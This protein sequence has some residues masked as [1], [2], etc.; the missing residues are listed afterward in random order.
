MTTK[1]TDIIF[2]IGYGKCASSTLQNAIFPLTKG[3]L[4][5]G[6]NT[7]SKHQ[8]SK[9]FQ[10]LAP[11]GPSIVGSIK[12]AKTW[13]KQVFDLKQKEFPDVDRLIVSS[14]FFLFNNI[15]KNR[16]IIPF[17]K[18]F[19]DTIWN[20]GEIKILIIIRNQAE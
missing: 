9:K 13:A 3:Y 10:A 14:E 18:Q 4:G 15:F 16:P 7:S 17:L 1:K 19:D 2:H 6:K 8:F 5:T 20:H 12:Q 11:C